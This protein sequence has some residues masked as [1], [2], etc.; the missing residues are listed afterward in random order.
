MNDYI[1][2][3]MIPKIEGIFEKIQN[4]LEQLSEE[5]NDDPK[6]YA[7]ERYANLVKEMLSYAQS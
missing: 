4:C 2:D 7:V 5:C 6:K 1:L 3:S